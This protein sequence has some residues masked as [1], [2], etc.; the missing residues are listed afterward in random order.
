VYYL[1]DIQI[2]S[3]KVT[4]LISN[5]NQPG[6]L[7]LL[8]MIGTRLIYKRFSSVSV[9]VFFFTRSVCTNCVVDFESKNSL[10]QP[11]V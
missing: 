1:I 9:I 10:W 3:S 2:D 7:E 5:K 6:G 11:K 4:M 8:K